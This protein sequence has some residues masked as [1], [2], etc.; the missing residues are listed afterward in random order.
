VEGA[1]GG[2][3]LEDRARGREVS[4]PATGAGKRGGELG[5]RRAA[6]GLKDLFGLVVRLPFDAQRLADEQQRDI[7]RGPDVAQ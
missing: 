1:L 5:D 7:R 4:P 3:A 6:G 2:Q